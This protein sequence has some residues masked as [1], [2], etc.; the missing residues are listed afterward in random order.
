M[1]YSDLKNLLNPEI[2]QNIDQEKNCVKLKEDSADAKLKS[3]WIYGLDKN[4]LVLKFDV[5][6]SK[7]T[8]F[9]KKSAY[10]NPIAKGIHKG[11]DYVLI[12]RHNKKNVIVF[13]ELKSNNISGAKQQLLSSIPFMDYLASLLKIH[14]NKDINE[15]KRYFILFSK[16]RMSKQRTKNSALRSEEYK[17]ISV[18]M[19]GNPGRINIG[20]IIK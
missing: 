5:Q 1:P 19:A 18:K 8:D 14:K 17:S 4:A 12:T 3:V 11:C 2:L 6:K 20:K 9:S 15:F 13:I 7:T 10:L 16:K